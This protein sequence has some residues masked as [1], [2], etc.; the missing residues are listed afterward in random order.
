[1]QFKPKETREEVAIVAA[2]QTTQP[3]FDFNTLMNFMFNFMMLTMFMRMV[4]T[5]LE[6]VTKAIGSSASL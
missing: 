3:I 4:N 6:S 1:M 2:S 5:M